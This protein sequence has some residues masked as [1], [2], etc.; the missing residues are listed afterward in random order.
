MAIATTPHL[1][2]RGDA[3]AALEFY[4]SVFGGQLVAV[5]YADAHAVTEPAE[6]SQLLWGQVESPDGFRV[7]AYDVPSHTEY[8]PGVIP[9]FVSIRSSDAAEIERYWSALAASSTVL[10]PLAPAAWAPLYGMATD[11]F[12]VTWVFDVAVPWAG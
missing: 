4:H 7:M 12:G 2:F 5:S 10:V 3:R 6:A 9:L 8:A 11:P 1:N